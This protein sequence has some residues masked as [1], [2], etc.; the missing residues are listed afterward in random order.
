LQGFAGIVGITNAL[1][2]ESQ[3]METEIM[4]HIGK[5]FWGVAAM[6]AAA[7]CLAS[8]AEA[9]KRCKG[10]DC[11]AYDEPGVYRYIRAEATF[12]SKSVIAP[13]R[14]GEWGDQVRTPGGNWVDCEV[15]CE[16][17][18]RRLTVDFWDGQGSGGSTITPGYFRYDIDLDTG[19]VR[20]RGPRIFRRY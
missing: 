17:T 19:E 9:G 11:R 14:H 5:A 6:S 20:R 13:V 4:G 12:G 3:A 16:Y 15:T 18:L 7:L 10:R 8:T 2:A 1:S